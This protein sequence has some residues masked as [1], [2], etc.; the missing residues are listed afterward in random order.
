MNHE[1]TMSFCRAEFDRSYI[2]EEEL[3]RICRERVGRFQPDVR[4]A[5]TE[6]LEIVARRI[7]DEVP[8]SLIRIGNGEGNAISMTKAVIHEPMFMTFST[9]FCCQNHYGIDKENAVRFCCEVVSAI[10]NADIIGFRS[11]YFNEN[12]VIRK[13]IDCGDAY[14]ALGITYAREFLKDS[15]INDRL[16]NKFVTSA[17]IHL[18][19]VPHL[20]ALFSMSEKIVIV[21]GRV[22]LEHEFERRLGSKL[23]RFIAVPAQGYVP[24]SFT[25]SHYASRFLQVQ[26]GL[27]TNLEGCLVLVGAG[28]F[29]KVYCDIAKRH[30]AVAIDL[31]SVFDVL[32]GLNTRPIF[33]RYKFEGAAWV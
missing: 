16:F 32:S 15:L 12:D 1:D 25:E 11:F 23:K 7:H 20:D 17:W 13:K 6:I 27:S 33:S 28:L 2:D 22:G 3:T 30:G 31:G 21:S 24:A 14:A 19:F 9:E 10:E 4:A 26:E 5:I 8:L 18:D 29:G